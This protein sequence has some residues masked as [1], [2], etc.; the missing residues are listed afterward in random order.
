MLDVGI[1]RNVVEYSP[2]IEVMMD[3]LSSRFRAK[4][5]H[6]CRIAKISGLTAGV[7]I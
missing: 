6:K 7:G 4:S 1:C 5:L 2:G 3:R